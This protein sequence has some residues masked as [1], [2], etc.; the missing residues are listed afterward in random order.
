MPNLLIVDD[1]PGILSA[2]RD[3]FVARGHDVTTAVDGKDALVKI[4]RERPDLVLLDL[5]LPELDGIGVLQKLRD[6]GIELTVVVITA[7]GTVDRAVAA[8]KAGAW[9]FIQKPF[10]PALVEE[11]VR[12]ALEREGL[13]TENRA[14]RASREDADPVAEDPRSK[15]LLDVVARAAKSAATVLLLGESGT[16]KE[17]LAREIHRRSPRAGGPF[18]AV[19]CVAI[20]ETLLESELFG[21][22]KGSFT[23][24][25]GRRQGKVEQAHRGTLFLDEIGDITPGF[26]SK[27]LRVLQ[28]RAFER[29]GG[30]ETIR[31]DIRV[32]AATN[33][34]L[35]AAVAEG[36]FREDLFYR[37]NVVTLS[38]PA[39]RERR[40]DIRPLVERFLA[41]A[42]REAK[43]PVPRVGEE[44]LRF[45]EA[46]EWPG[47]VRELKNVVERAVVLL[48][49][50]ELTLDDLPAE[51]LSGGGG[52]TPGGFHERVA[53][54]RR[55]LIREALEASGGNQTRAAEALGLQR[56]YLARLIRQ[57]GG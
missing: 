54:F 39:L 15:E 32:V 14:L 47:N 18:V 22:E 45:L 33:R 44:V 9:D 29:V 8:M 21:H 37:L 50:D 3:R 6:D 7:F 51:M 19:N 24:A 43:R 52:V 1:D 28:E 16:G 49:G 11:T 4:R 30:N 27:L 41:G 56:T 46:Q 26:Q 31:V 34:D 20:T 42:S 35:K 25:V 38:V 5:Q 55:K 57:M 2:L 36:K 17:V 23:G 48:D 40:A 12:R 53:E 10:E 13:R